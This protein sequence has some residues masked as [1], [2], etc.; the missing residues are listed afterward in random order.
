MRS[1]FGSRNTSSF[2]AG[3]QCRHPLQV[4]GHRHPL[5]VVAGHHHRHPMIMATMPTA[6]VHLDL[7]RRL[8]TP[9]RRLRPLRIG[10]PLRRS[11]PSRV[12]PA[13]YRPSQEYQRFLRP[14]LMIVL[15]RKMKPSSREKWLHI[16]I[17]K[18]PTPRRH[19]PRSKRYG[20]LIFL[21][22]H[23]SMTYMRSKITIHAHLRGN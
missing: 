6:L 14:V 17:R 22:H 2:Q 8:S 18:N 23:A 19:T 15:M 9:P 7:H 11:V 16:F 20:L 10:R 12:L 3:H 4:A 21:T 5:R 13:N 1:F